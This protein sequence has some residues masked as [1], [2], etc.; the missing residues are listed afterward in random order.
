MS[1]GIDV[2]VGVADGFGEVHCCAGADTV[3]KRLGIE[4]GVEVSDRG[5]KA[6]DL[7]DGGVVGGGAVDG[8]G[9]STSY[10]L[11]RLCDL[12]CRLPSAGRW[13]PARD[14]RVRSIRLVGC[15]GRAGRQM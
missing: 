4:G 7:G 11:V 2:V 13:R 12:L 6:D 15:L 5:G 14:C 9:V 1:G 8:G 10:S 3:V